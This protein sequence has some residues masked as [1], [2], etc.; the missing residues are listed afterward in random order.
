[1]LPVT[2]RPMLVAQALLV[3]LNKNVAMASFAPTVIPDPLAAVVV[4]AVLA[5][6]IVLASV[7]IL[8]IS[9]MLPVTIKL[10]PTDKSPPTSMYCV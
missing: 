4:F 5:N 6:C 9:I 8:P 7:T 2:L 1:M 3:L 10:P